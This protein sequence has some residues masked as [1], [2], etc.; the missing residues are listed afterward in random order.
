ML[1]AGI[2]GSIDETLSLTNVVFVRNETIGDL[3]VEEG[4]YFKTIFDLGFSDR[5]RFPWHDGKLPNKG[6]MDLGEP[7]TILDGITV[8]EIST[9]K[10]RIAYYKSIGAAVETMEGAAF[11]YVSLLENIPFLQI[12]SLS[13]FVG[14]RDKSKWMTREAISTLNSNLQRIL[15]TLI[16]R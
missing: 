6:I 15:V 11:H 16:Q 12:R 3:G 2:A 13:N 5:N 7:V 4:G 8:N 1:Q 9:D 10:N 14:E